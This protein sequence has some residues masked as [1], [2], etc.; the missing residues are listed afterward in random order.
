MGKTRA[1]RHKS[2]HGLEFFNRSRACVISYESRARIWVNR[3]RA[4]VASHGLACMSL[5]KVRRRVIVEVKNL[6]VGAPH[7]RPTFCGGETTVSTAGVPG[8]LVLSEDMFEMLWGWAVSANHGPWL[9][10]MRAINNGF[11]CRSNSF[12]WRGSEQR[13]E[14]QESDCLTQ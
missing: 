13:R 7:R 5:G 3:S 12:E 6:F 2:S 1:Y 14:H 4:C 10:M 8:S 11:H 9:V